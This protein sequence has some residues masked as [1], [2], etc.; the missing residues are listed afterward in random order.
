M[1][2]VL[3]IIVPSYNMEDY[4][5]KGLGS[6]LGIP[7]PSVLDVIVVNDGSKDRTLEIARGFESRYPDVVTVIDK[8]NGNYGSCINAALKE[9]RGKYVKVLD[10]DDYVDSAAFEA[11]VKILETTDA[12]VIVNDYQKVYTG[13]KKKD[14]TRL[15]Q[16]FICQRSAFN[17]SRFHTSPSILRVFG[18]VCL[19]DKEV[20]QCCKF[21]RILY[22]RTHI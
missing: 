5:A 8:E 6:V 17:H 15:D 14:F 13:G 16:F 7:D 10:A 4:L 9:A 21:Y 11:L 18:T 22:Y 12:D 3:S 20:D 19:T 1:N 2:K